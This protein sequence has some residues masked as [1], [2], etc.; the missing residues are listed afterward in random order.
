MSKYASTIKTSEIMEEIE[1]ILIEQGVTSM[2]GLSTVINVDQIIASLPPFLS[3]LF[4]VLTSE[5]VMILWFAGIQILVFVTGLQ[6]IDK[7]VYEASS[8]DGANKWEQ[9]WKVTFPAIN[10]VIISSFSPFG[11]IST[12]QKS[13]L[14]ASQIL[15][16]NP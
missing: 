4:S 1:K 11:V 9:F 2:P 14:R 7:G 12:Q 15:L 13:S 5:F 8:I 10:P 6:R 16:L 3:N